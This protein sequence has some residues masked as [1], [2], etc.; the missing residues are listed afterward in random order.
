[1][2]QA[3]TVLQDAGATI[4]RANIPT[5]GWMGGPASDMPILNLN[6]ESAAAGKDDAR[7]VVPGRA[8][9]DAGAQVDAVEHE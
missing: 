5:I 3:I 2:A 4:V 1:M 7:A 9:L 6:P 8:D